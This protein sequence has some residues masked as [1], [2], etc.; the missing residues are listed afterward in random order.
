[1]SQAQT[2]TSATIA[3]TPPTAR[4]TALRPPARA[5]PTTGSLPRVGAQVSVSSLGA[6][7]P[8]LGA[9]FMSLTAMWPAAPWP[10]LEAMLVANAP[11]EV[12]ML[13][14]SEDREGTRTYYAVAPEHEGALANAL[15]DLE[16][17]LRRRFPTLPFEVVLTA[18]QGHSPASAVP[19]SAT[20]IGSAGRHG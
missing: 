13:A 1:M 6:T 8:V 14:R 19:A 12:A 5:R 20:V 15:Y 7:P 16:A 4:T 2:D 9:A 18:H 3:W 11:A 10:A 17:E